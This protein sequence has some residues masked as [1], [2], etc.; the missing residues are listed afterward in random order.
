MDR[1]TGEMVTRPAPPDRERQQEYR[2]TV[3]VEDDGTPPLSVRRSLYFAPL[4]VE[5]P[6]WLVMAL[7]FFSS[8]N[9]TQGFIDFPSHF[10]K[11]SSG[12]T[13]NYNLFI[14]MILVLLFSSLQSP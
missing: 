7:R 3:T 8:S 1:M 10:I 13:V 14:S 12:Q 9:F 11:P 5:T 2:L 4:V 6:I